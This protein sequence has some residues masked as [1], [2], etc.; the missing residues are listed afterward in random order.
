MFH[1]KLLTIKL[2]FSILVLSS[3]LEKTDEAPKFSAFNE[4][5]IEIDVSMSFSNMNLSDFEN[6]RLEYM[7]K[8]L[9]LVRTKVEDVKGKYIALG[10]ICEDQKM[11]VNVSNVS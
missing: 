7:T 3:A 5:H 9:E 11:Q 10:N 8:G 1:T 6:M 4:T 2:L